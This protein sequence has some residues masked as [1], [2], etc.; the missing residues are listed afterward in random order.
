[1]RILL[2]GCTRLMA[3]DNVAKNT[4]YVSFAPILAEL[5][6]EVPGVQVDQTYVLP[7]DEHRMEQYDAAL[8]GLAAVNGFSGKKH[9]WSALWALTQLPHVIWVDDWQVGSLISSLRREKETWKTALLT[10][11]ELEEREHGLDVKDEI[12]AAR[13]HVHR[14][15]TT[16]EHGSVLAPLF[17]WGDHE[18]FQTEALPCRTLYALDPSN[19]VP[20]KT[21]LT[22][23]PFEDKQRAWAYAGLKDHRRF[24]ERHETTWP[25]RTIMPQQGKRGGWGRITEDRV[26]KELYEPNWGNIVVP[27]SQKMRSTGWWRSRYNFA[28]QAGNVLWVSPDDL[29]R[30]EPSHFPGISEVESLNDEEL[31][32]LH[33]DQVEHQ[34]NWHMSRRD[35]LS[36][37]INLTNNWEEPIRV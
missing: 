34:R 32:A 30:L 21:D 24:F 26:V 17:P 1:M 27:Y 9:R 2:T 25:V 22:Y 4:D 6:R 16:G 5:L 14:G 19:F 23:P 35:A 29:G 15:F 37:L 7:G 28:A 8:V 3:G 11:E 12:E 31:E 10:H 33:F 36:V 18:K 20:W 13:L